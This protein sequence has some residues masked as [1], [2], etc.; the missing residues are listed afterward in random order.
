LAAEPAFVEHLRTLL[1]RDE[2]DR[3][4]RFRF[5]RHRAAFTLSRGLL[6]VI[7]A[8]LLNL[9]P[10]AVRFAYGPHGKPAV[11]GGGRLQFNL[12]HSGGM[13]VYAIGEGLD[14]GIDVERIRPLRDLHGVARRFFSPAEYADLQSIDSARQEAAFFNCWTR[15]ESFIKA[16]GEGMAFPLHR[17]QVSLRPEEP[18]RL[19][20]IDGSIDLAQSWSLHDIAPAEGYAAAVAVSAG[21]CRLEMHKFEDTSACAHFFASGL[22]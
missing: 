14:V 19:V 2:L 3:A 8:N 18:V 12:S 1:S 17:F 13:T 5:E 20:A 22:F 6:R 7:L 16:L 9:D 4:G 15:K 11:L 10:A 21:D